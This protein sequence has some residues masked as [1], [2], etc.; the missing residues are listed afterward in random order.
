MN[1]GKGLLKAYS[2]PRRY[3]GP[4]AA[5]PL[6]ASQTAPALAAAARPTKA[7][8]LRSLG[9][10]RVHSHAAHLGGSVDGL[11]D[12]SLWPEALQARAQSIKTFAKHTSQ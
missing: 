12:Q 3:F 8:H 9:A 6:A 1:G 4:L 2:K 10:S 7:S 5:A 11:H